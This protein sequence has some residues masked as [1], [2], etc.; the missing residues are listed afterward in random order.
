MAI[1]VGWTLPVLLALWLFGASL[2]VD[3][4]VAFFYGR[5]I[6][7]EA[8]LYDAIVLQPSSNLLR[9]V[10]AFQTGERSRLL[11]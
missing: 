8:R 6:P 1:R 7:D 9:L 11:I 10:S 4:S 2:P 5:G 3:A